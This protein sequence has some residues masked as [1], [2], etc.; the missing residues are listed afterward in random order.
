M[1]YA[2]TDTDKCISNGNWKPLGICRVATTFLRSEGMINVKFCGA[3]RRANRGQ[4]NLF[5]MRLKSNLDC[6]CP[7]FKEKSPFPTVC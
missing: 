7:P 1:N 2:T 3:A 5:V 4:E 6:F